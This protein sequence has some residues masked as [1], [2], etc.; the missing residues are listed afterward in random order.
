MPIIKSAAATSGDTGSGFT[1]TYWFVNESTNSALAHVGGAN[2][3]Y[4]LNNSLGSRSFNHNPE[5]KS[6]LWNPSTNKFEFTSLKV[7]DLVTVTG[8]ITFDNLAAQGVDIF[9]SMAEGTATAHEH[10]VNHTYF[11]T[12]MTGRE[13]SFTYPILMHDADAIAGGARIRFASAQAASISGDTW[14]A[15]VT[16]V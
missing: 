14:T 1:K 4:L 10:V 13:V 7:G 12:A 2:D 3:T 11:K 15:V 9:I 16:E 5:S 6:A 8:N